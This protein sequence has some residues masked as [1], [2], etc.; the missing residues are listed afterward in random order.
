MMAIYKLPL[1]YLDTWRAK[2]AAVTLAEVNA[3]IRRHLKPDAMSVITVGRT[4]PTSK[5]PSP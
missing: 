3:A 5:T 1:D 2:L 4:A